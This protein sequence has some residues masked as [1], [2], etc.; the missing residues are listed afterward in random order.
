MGD[1][2]DEMR[3]KVVYSHVVTMPIPLYERIKSELQKLSKGSKSGGGAALRNP[4]S[5]SAQR[6]GECNDSSCPQ[7]TEYR[8]YC[9]RAQA[10]EDYYNSIGVDIHGD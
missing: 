9:V 5:C 7:L 2:L 4:V 8:S 6:D 10:E 1:L 3:E